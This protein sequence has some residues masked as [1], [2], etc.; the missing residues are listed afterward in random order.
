MEYEENPIPEHLRHA[1][2]GRSHHVALQKHALGSACQLRWHGLNVPHMAGLPL[3]MVPWYVAGPLAL[4]APSWGCRGAVRLP[5]G[6]P[7]KVR[8]E[9]RLVRPWPVC[10]GSDSPSRKPVL[11]TL[12]HPPRTLGFNQ[13]Y[14][15]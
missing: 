5:G 10:A 1:P 9:G 14:V 12:L 8:R 2:Q 3:S 7:H 13:I 15:A 11:S 6:H 4:S